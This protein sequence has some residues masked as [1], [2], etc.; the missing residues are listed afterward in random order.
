MRRFVEFEGVT[1]SVTNYL[2][3]KYNAAG[4]QQWEATYDDPGGRYFESY[5]FA[6]AVD[7]LGNVYITG[8][9]GFNR[10]EEDY[11]TVKY[12]SRGRQLWAARYTSYDF[13]HRAFDLA[14]DGQGNV[15]VTGQSDENYV[16]IKYSTNGMQQWV[17]KGNNLGFGAAAFSIAVDALGSVYV[18]GEPVTIKYTQ[19]LPACGNK[20]QNVLVCHNGKKTLC[21]DKSE[22]AAHIRHGDYVGECFVEECSVIHT[23]RRE[24]ATGSIVLPD[25]FRVYTAPNPA[26]TTTKIYYEL[27]SDGHVTI[28][29][30]DMLGQVIT[31]LVDAGQQAGFHNRE[32]NVAALPKG[33]Y[34]YQ[35]T[36]KAGKKCKKNMFQLS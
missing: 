14:L 19:P 27:P 10:D 6:I 33:M 8:Q 22:L 15:Y 4:V 26:I 29:I 21:V 32:F 30:F 17:A 25:R 28:K 2:T 34:Y 1:Y 7:K 24:T 18:T 23:E 13:D 16:T 9:S 20:N 36:V 11:A 3:V 12:D 35:A 31:T 5:P